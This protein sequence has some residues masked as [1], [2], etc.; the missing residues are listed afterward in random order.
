MRTRYCCRISGSG[1]MKKSAA[2]SRR[3]CPKWT[4]WQVATAAQTGVRLLS[5]SQSS[6]SSPSSHVRHFL[7]S[8]PFRQRSKRE[9]KEASYWNMTSDGRMLPMQIPPYKFLFIKWN[10]LFSHF[11]SRFLWTDSCKIMHMKYCSI[12]KFWMWRSLSYYKR[13]GNDTGLYQ[14]WS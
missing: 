14:Y 7:P 13:Y 10:S 9:A 2:N 12:Q 11:S 5:S 1:M 6:Q 3:R 8:N 4:R